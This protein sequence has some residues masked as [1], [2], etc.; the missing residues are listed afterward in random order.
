MEGVLVNQHLGEASLLWIFECG[1]EGPR[2]VGTRETPEEGGGSQR[3]LEMA[4][5][6]R[7]C[8]ALLV[9]GVGPNPRRVIEGKG[10]RVLEMAG[11]ISEGVESLYHDGDIP[12]AMRKHFRS[13]GAECQGSG[14]GCS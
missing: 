3:W 9:G 1:P 13:C 12:R 2:L 7:D 8:R 6:L 5:S 4:E 10:I 14:M 11:F